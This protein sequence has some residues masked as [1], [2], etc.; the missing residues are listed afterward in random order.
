[1]PY[2]KYRYINV[3]IYLV[4]IKIITYLKTLDQIIVV[5]I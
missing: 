5:L 2:F 3:S 4:F 1:M